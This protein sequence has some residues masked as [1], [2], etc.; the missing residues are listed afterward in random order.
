MDDKIQKYQYNMK[1]IFYKKSKD[2]EF[3]PGDLFLKWEAR[4]E[5]TG[6]HGKFYHL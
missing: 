3:L 1:T 6:K 5:D 2:V 4:N